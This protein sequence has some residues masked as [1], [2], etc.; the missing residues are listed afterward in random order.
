[1]T[2]RQFTIDV[3]PEV[4]GRIAARLA[5]TRI[6]YE[7]AGGGWQ[8]GTDRDYLE[9]FV[10]YWRESYDWPEQQRR[11]NAFAHFRAEV[12]GIDIHFIH[13]RG[14]GSQAAP[15][16]LTHGWP[17]SV[18]EFVEVI[19][20]LVAAGFDVVVPSLPGYGWSGRPAFPIGPATVARLW[21]KL[22][23]EELGYNRFFAQGGDWGSAVTYQLG[24]SHADVV[25]AIHLN[26][27]MG[28]SP[29]SS[30]DSELAEYW[31]AVGALTKEESGY[32]HQQGT[33]PQTLGLALH[34][35]PVGWASWLLEKFRR[36]GETNGDIESRF[37]KDHLITNM[38]S[39]LVTDNVMSSLWMYYASNHEP[40]NPGPVQVPTAL[41][42]FP[43]EFYPMPSLRVAEMAHNVVRFTTMAAGGHFAAMEEP[44]AFAAD[45]IAFF[46]SQR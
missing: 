29:G 12:E 44:E 15:I 11:L 19:P 38:M 35:N 28:P 42:H 17:G 31:K 23:T 26:F 30:D 5:D 14:N 20:A 32:Q 41:A 45:V 4:L 27:Y 3:P 40:R 33:R 34:D 25:A 1:M 18:I 21:R 39:Y 24:A 16:L 46:S 37:S 10:R 13:V 36:W 7:P 43:G 22:M 9:E 6:G 8:W 2:V